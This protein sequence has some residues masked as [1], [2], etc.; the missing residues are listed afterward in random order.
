MRKI[1]N[2]KI[3]EKAGGRRLP[4]IGGGRGN[5]EEMASFAPQYTARAVYIRVKRS[6]IR[7]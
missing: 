5:G 4:G 3:R 2:K 7:K 1:K 6:Y